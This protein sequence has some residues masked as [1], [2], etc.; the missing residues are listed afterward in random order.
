VYGVGG[1]LERKSRV[2]W[3]IILKLISNSKRW[4]RLNLSGSGQRQVGVTVD[5]V[6]KYRVR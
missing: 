6:T 1:K 3:E 2:R 5:M 4:C